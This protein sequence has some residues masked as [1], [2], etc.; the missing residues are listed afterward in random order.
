M[1]IRDT[2]KSIVTFGAPDLAV[3]QTVPPPTV[4]RPSALLPAGPTWQKGRATWPSYSVDTFATSGYA[5]LATVYRCVNILANA[6]ATAPVKVYQDQNGQPDEQPDHPLRTLLRFPN[7]A[8]SEAEFLNTIAKI[9]AVAGFVVCWKVRGGGGRVLELQP[10]RSDWLTP[11]PR[12]DGIDHDWRYTLPDGARYHLDAEDV[13]PWT[14][15][16][17]PRLSPCG[18]PPL[19]AALREVGIAGELATFVK[20]FFERGAVPYFGLILDPEI[21][22]DAG[23]A[24]ALRQKFI[25]RSGLQHAVD[26][27]ILQSIKD[28]KRLGIDLNE[29]AASE[30]RNLTQLDITTAFGVPPILV[31]IQAGL[32]A[33]TYSNYASARRSFYEDT[34]M[35]LWSRLDGALSRSLLPEFADAG[36]DLAFDLADVPALRDDEDAAWARANTAVLGGWATVADARRAVGLPELPGTD[37][38]LRQISLM[39]IEPGAVQEPAVDRSAGPGATEVRETATE[40]RAKQADVSRKTI[41]RIAERHEPEIARYFAEQADRVVA[42]ATRSMQLVGVVANG[43]GHAP[44][45]RSLDSLDWDD[46]TRRLQAVIGRLSRSAGAAAAGSVSQATGVVVDFTLANPWVHTVLGKL[47]DRVVDISETTRKDIQRVVGQALDDGVSAPQLAERLTGLFE[48]T[49]ANRSTV[50]ARTESMMAYGLASAEGYRQSGVVDEVML[51]DN[52]NHTDP[53]PGAEDGWTCAERHGKTVPL[54]DVEKH[55]RSEH[56]QGSLT[57]IPVLSGPALGEG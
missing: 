26:P 19:A 45:T 39:E 2:L 33:S 43:N 23:E 22:F 21:E 57:I 52:P 15:E 54:R 34:I 6:I 12:G 48:Q 56:P 10:L 8:Q 27:V 1:T 4:I 49:Y 37:V 40:T 53:Y 32:D 47:A 55:L 30:I 28:V 51:Y 35:P 20:S 17:D 31:G 7:R 9:A 41:A 36:L 18:V 3:R 44:E 16:S 50:I 14:F 25:D 46:E 29:L 38:F 5:Q 24:E 42:A 11:I 13:V